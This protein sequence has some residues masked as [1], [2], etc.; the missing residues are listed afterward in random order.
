MT[1]PANIPR[2]IDVYRQPETCI[3]QKADAEL[4]SYVAE[5]MRRRNP[6]VAEPAAEF[7]A[8]VHEAA[9]EWSQAETKREERTDAIETATRANNAATTSQQVDPPRDRER[10]RK[11]ER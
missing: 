3:V 7:A 10:T 5:I 11:R 6:E 4:Q 2:P 9:D 1:T 8:K